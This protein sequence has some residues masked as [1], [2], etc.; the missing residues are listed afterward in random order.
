MRVDELW[1][2][3]LKKEKKKEESENLRKEKYLVFAICTAVH[4]LPSDRR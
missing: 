3:F 4:E 2:M 1:V